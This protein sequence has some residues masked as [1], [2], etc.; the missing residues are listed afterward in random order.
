MLK[1]VGRLYHLEQLR[2]VPSPAAYTA[3]SQR[4][5]AR[6]QVNIRKCLNCNQPGHFSRSCPHPRR[7]DG[8]NSQYNAQNNSALQVN[9]VAGS[10]KTNHNSYLRVII[11][12][13]I[14]D[15][16]L[17]AGSDVCLIPEH[18][19]DPASIKWTGHTLIAVNGTSIPTLG[20]VTLPL[21]VGQF[22]T[23]VRGLVSSHVVE[24]VLGTDFLVEN[25]A[26]WDFDSSTIRLGNKTFRLHSRFDKRKWCRHVVLQEDIFVPARSEINLPMQTEFQK[27]PVIDVDGH[28][29]AE[30]SP[31]KTVFRVSR[32]LTPS[33]TFTDISEG[34]VNVA[35]MLLKSETVEADLQPFGVADELT[36][37]KSELT[38]VKRPEE[39]VTVINVVEYVSDDQ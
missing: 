5:A 9:G 16:L 29:C 20:E 38:Q 33:G 21:R 2:S 36:D 25:K 39:A 8:E 32:A 37:V 13:S 28:C 14:H 24:P 27:F 31:V 4:N 22:T 18:L 19:V 30:L 12:D 11:G 6:P 34:V 17:D 26:N 7:Q 15:C 35:K 1:E 3:S 10:S 23:Q